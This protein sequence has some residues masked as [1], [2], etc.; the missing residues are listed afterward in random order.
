MEMGKGAG[1]NRRIQLALKRAFD[2]V[3]SALLLLLFL[4]LFPLIALLIWLTMGCPVLFR[5]PR[6]GYQGRPFII[7][8]F[9][10]MADRRDEHGHL[11]P[12]EQRLSWAGRF[13]R[14]LTLDEL[15]ELFNVLKGEMSLVGPRPLLVEYRDLYTPEQWR[16]HEMPPGMA[17]PVLADG[18]NALDWEEKFRRDLWYV[19]NWSLWLDFQ[20]LARTAWKVL[21][22]EGVSAKGYAT[23]PRFEGSSRHGPTGHPEV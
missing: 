9:R 15:P 23:M 21:K 20:I 11:L 2:I 19:D 7:Y 6:L 16:R 13:L 18:R 22:R 10:T 5:Q 17:G 1:M 14:S 3:V 8:K 4:P 12:D